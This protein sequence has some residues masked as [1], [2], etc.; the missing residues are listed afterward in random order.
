MNTFGIIIYHFSIGRGAMNAQKYWN[1]AIMHVDCRL[2]DVTSTNTP[3]FFLAE[4][5]IRI[6]IANSCARSPTGWEWADFSKILRT[7][8]LN[9]YLSKEPNFSRFHLAEQYL[10][11]VAVGEVVLLSMQSN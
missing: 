6:P 9:K 7:S 1:C 2:Y 8:L 3:R 10:G 11:L 4:L 5:A